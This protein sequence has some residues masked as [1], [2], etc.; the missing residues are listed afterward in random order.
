M[1]SVADD[2]VE[3]VHLFIDNQPAPTRE[4]RKVVTTM[5]RI[6]CLLQDLDELLVFPDYACLSPPLHADMDAGMA[7]CAATLNAL[8]KVLV[9]CRRGGSGGWADTQL[10]FRNRE[11]KSLQDALTASREFLYSMKTMLDT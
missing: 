4:I 9:R 3:T 11:G 10:A 1:A 6:K 7:A 8:G 5:Y 2:L